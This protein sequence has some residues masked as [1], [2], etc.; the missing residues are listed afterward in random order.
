ML[1]AH[2]FRN[3]IGNFNFF[4]MPSLSAVQVKVKESTREVCPRAQYGD[5][6]LAI[7][8][9]VLS[10]SLM[11]EVPPSLFEYLTEPPKPDPQLS[12]KVGDV[13][14]NDK[15]GASSM[16]GLLELSLLA[17]TKMFARSPL[18]N[19]QCPL[20]ITELIEYFVH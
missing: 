15:D 12:D 13:Q 4:H 7:V 5:V 3:R 14:L 11:D 18:F 9:K 6:P 8:P 19:S 17:K 1:V 2:A 16:D 10:P 20:T